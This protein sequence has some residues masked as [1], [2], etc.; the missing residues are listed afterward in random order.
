MMMCLGASAAISSTRE[1]VV[2]ADDRRLAQ[3]P[4]IAREVV[5]EGVVVVEKQNH[6]AVPGASRASIERPRLVERLPVFLLGIG[7]GDD[8]AAGLKVYPAP[9]CQ[10]GADDDARVHRAGGRLR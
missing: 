9:E 3:L 2:P 7:V 4:D 6:G 5:D 8:A 10:I 1:R